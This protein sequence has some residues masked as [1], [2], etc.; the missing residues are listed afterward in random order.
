MS[1]Y[2]YNKACIDK[3]QAYVYYIKYKLKRQKHEGR[4]TIIK[5]SKGLTHMQDL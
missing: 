5:S 1:G 3:A 2:E 4:K